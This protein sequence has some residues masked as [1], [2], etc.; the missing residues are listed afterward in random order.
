M[1]SALLGLALLTACAAPGG[2]PATVTQLTAADAAT[3]LIAGER[4]EMRRRSSGGGQ[5]QDSLVTLALRHGDG[6]E[7]Q[8]QEANHT[9][10]D[11]MAQEPGGPLSQIMGFFADETPVLYHATAD[12]NRSEPFLCGPEGPVAIGVHEAADG[13]TQIVGLRQPI[14][15][16]ALPDGGYEAAPY[17][18][19]MVCARLKFRRS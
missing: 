6:R 12:R 17:S 1:R 13:E 10:T 15:F 11:L 3:A 14:Q 16:D 19:D 5:G 8:F 18:P 4:L 2:G 9:P 7:L